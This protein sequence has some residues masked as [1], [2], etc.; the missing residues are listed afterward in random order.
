MHVIVDHSIVAAIFTNRTSITARV[1]PAMTD[2]GVAAGAGAVIKGA[3][4]LATANENAHL[5]GANAPKI[6]NAQACLNCAQ[7]G[8]K[9]GVCTKWM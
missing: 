1:Q 6:H 2:G 3:W 7:G 8:M 5:P 4:P 9:D